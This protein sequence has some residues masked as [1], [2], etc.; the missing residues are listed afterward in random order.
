MVLEAN[1]GCLAL[2][3]AFANNTHHFE[4]SGQAPYELPCLLLDLPDHVVQAILPHMT[5]R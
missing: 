5:Q 1:W 3:A 4:P 2:Q